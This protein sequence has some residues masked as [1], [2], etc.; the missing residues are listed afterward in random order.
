MLNGAFI[1][2]VFSEKPHS[3]F[4]NNIETQKYQKLT[5]WSPLA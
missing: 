4:E 1:L 3:D 2:L 5:P